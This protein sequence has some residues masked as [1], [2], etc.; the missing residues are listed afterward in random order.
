MYYFYD[1]TYILV[2]IGA[3]ISL[4]ASMN[5]KSTFN[6]YDKY[7]SRSGLTGAMAAQEI[8]RAAGIT[9]VRIERV[10]G[11]LT[12]HYSPKEGVLRLSD[13]VYNSTSVAAIGVAA[14]EC[15]HAM[16]YDEE[17]FPIKIRAAVIPIANIGSALSWPIILLGLFLGAT[18]LMQ[19][20]SLVVVFQLLTLPVEFDASARALRT[21]RER[22]ML[23]S[24]ELTGARKVLI[25]AA[26][27]YVA[28]LLTS[29]LQLLRLVLLTRRDD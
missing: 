25:A 11:N 4:I 24:S 18:G 14:H 9:N 16:Q 22:N 1:A 3:I 27:T 6:R 19:L 7:N 5:V 13:S 10:S 12:D 28:A 17:Y 2:I 8:L 26:L 29:I 20:F 23:E 21:L 15:G